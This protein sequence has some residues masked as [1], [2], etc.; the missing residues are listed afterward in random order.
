MGGTALTPALHDSLDSLLSRAKASGAFTFVNT[1]YDFRNE[2]RAPGAPWPLG[3]S[4]AS[5]ASIDLLVTDLEEARRLSGAG[6]AAAALAFFRD[7][8]VGAAVVTAG[9]QGNPGRLLEGRGL[10]GLG[11]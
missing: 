5:Y 9:H 6:D 8:G 1:V 2:S 3:S 10:S 4:D 7:R 11:T